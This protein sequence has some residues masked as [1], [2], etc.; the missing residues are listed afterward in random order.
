MSR[1]TK[2]MLDDVGRWP[3]WLPDPD[4]IPAILLILAGLVVVGAI[5]A[6]VYFLQ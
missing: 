2:N 5:G 4:H 1:F 6:A 3:N